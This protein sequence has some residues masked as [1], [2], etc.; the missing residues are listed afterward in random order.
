[1]ITEIGNINET[2]ETAAL[3][4]ELDNLFISTLF[5]MSLNRGNNAVTNETAITEWGRIKVKKAFW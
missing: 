3:L 2:N 4:I 5:A 1:M